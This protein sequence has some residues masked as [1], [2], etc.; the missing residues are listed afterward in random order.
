M[1]EQL[2]D[3]IVRVGKLEVGLAQLAV[4]VA[5]QGVRMD[6]LGQRTGRNERRLE[7]VGSE[8]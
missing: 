3:L 4:T 6:R 7:F 1:R 8:A 5:E 2:R